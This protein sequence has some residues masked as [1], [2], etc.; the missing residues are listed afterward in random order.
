MILRFGA[1]T[2]SKYTNIF[3][4][5]THATVVTEEVPESYMKQ[6]SLPLA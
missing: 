2:A 6:V 5:I 4:G 1:S 3:L